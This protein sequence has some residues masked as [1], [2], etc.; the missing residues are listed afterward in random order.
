MKIA[1]VAIAAALCLAAGTVCA[2]SAEDP[3]Q[4][5]WL[6]GVPL[7]GQ[8]NR[9]PSYVEVAAKY[10]GDAG[11]RQLMEKVKRVAPGLGSGSDAAESE[12]LR[13]RSQDDRYLHTRVSEVTAHL[14]GNRP[15][16][17]L[18]GRDDEIVLARREVPAA[19]DAASL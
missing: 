3:D 12:R 8:E 7:H 2:Q 16:S 4:E 9:R 17:Y 18:A 10:K 14:P 13:R 6:L 11:P 15:P 5:G 19:R 1:A